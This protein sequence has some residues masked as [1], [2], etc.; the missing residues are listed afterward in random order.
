[1]V[2]LLLT[3]AIATSILFLAYRIKRQRLLRGCFLI[4]GTALATTAISSLIQI[5]ETGEGLDGWRR[6]NGAY[7]QALE[8]I[9]A[10]AFFAP[11]FHDHPEYREKLRVALANDTA[12]PGTNTEGLIYTT[13]SKEHGVPAVR[14]AEDELL[15]R[16]WQSRIEI[17]RWLSTR[18]PVACKAFDL[19]QY[20]DF[21]KQGVAFDSLLQSFFERMGAAYESGKAKPRQTSADRDL[22]GQVLISGR[23]QLTEADAASLNDQGSSPEAYCHAL[24]KSMLSVEDVP[25]V[26]RAKYIRAFY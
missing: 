26:D 15:I 18:D 9:Q 3:L 21:K 8:L 22:L 12:S 1:M 4:A 10:N 11:L 5:W 14:E 20:Q 23:H 19:G 7:E 13:L 6:D 17:I 25:T 16:V 24:L 2:S